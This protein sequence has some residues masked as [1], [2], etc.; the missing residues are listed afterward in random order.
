MLSSH[1]A[2]SL[3]RD[4]GPAK[5]CS[6][7]SQR[8]EA[9]PRFRIVTHFVSGESSG[10]K[11]IFIFCILLF[12]HLFLKLIFS[13][14]NA[15]LPFHISSVTA[16]GNR[17]LWHVLLLM[18]ILPHWQLS[19][20][21]HPSP[22]SVKIFCCQNHLIFHPPPHKPTIFYHPCEQDSMPYTSVHLPM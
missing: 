11:R 10:Q 19:F 22:G 7:V 16:I 4:A 2:A 9:A 20:S 18:R 5:R 1:T 21:R 14:P 13:S 8:T 6:R 15:A 3:C 12:K 17:S